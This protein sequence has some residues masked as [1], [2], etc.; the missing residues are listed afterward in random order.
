M[1]TFLEAF[2]KGVTFL[3]KAQMAAG[4]LTVATIGFIIPLQ[5]FCRYV[6]NAPLMWPEDIGIGL[7][8]WGGFIG[9]AI[10]YKRNGHVAI[11]FLM[12]YCPPRVSQIISLIIDLMVAFLSLIIIVYGFSLNQFQMMTIQV[13]TG[14]PRGYFYSLPL[15]VNTVAMFLYALH[16]LLKR[17]SGGRLS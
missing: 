9:A 7:M 13:G 3:E 10:L 15:F 4:I 1:R 16:A 8:V 11:E 14:I 17:T 2:T 5:V 6:L 12:N